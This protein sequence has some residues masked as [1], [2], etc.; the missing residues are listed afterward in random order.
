MKDG[1]GRWL[2]GAL[3]A[4]ASN[5]LAVLSEPILV[6]ANP[7]SQHWAALTTNCVSLGWPWNTNSV[8][9][10]LE[11][12][13]MQSA[14]VANFPEGVSSYLWRP[15]VSDAPSVE[16]VYELKLTMY[17]TNSQIVDSQ[18]SQ[19]AV[20]A[21]AFASVVVDA[22]SE[23]PAW[24]KVKTNVVIPYAPSFSDAADNAFSAQLV[25]AKDG[26]AVQTNVFA[27]AAGY[28]GWKIKNSGWGYGAFELGLTFP[29][30]GATLLM[31]E[32][33]HPLDG[34][35]IRVR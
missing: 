8:N 15:F 16:D 11:V 27:E 1:M 13:G 21:G 2:L 25:I 29:G 33:L 6:D 9:V 3:C 32:L 20:I 35:M 17:D 22:A 34:T 12:T 10:K 24:S 31:A 14:F 30:T 19:L 7:Q 28:Y 5:G 26:G 18:T 23:S 4:A